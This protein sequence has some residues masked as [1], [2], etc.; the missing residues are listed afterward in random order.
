MLT[1]QEVT[2]DKETEDKYFA[3]VVAE[4]EAGIRCID[5]GDKLPDPPGPDF[6]PGVHERC[7]R[8]CGLE[9]Y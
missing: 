5:C 9:R 7:C 8:S 3:E 6:V 2:L 1:Y 4:I